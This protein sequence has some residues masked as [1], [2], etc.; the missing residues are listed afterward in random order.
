MKRD[1]IFESK[2]ALGFS[3]R[4]FHTVNTQRHDGRRK[5]ETNA[6]SITTFESW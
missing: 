2:E 1:A 4:K 6:P 3:G 5:N